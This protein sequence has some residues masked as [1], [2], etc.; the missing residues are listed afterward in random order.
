VILSAAF[1]VFYNFTWVLAVLEM[2]KTEKSDEPEKVLAPEA[3]P[4]G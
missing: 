3:E 1:A 2:V 4:A